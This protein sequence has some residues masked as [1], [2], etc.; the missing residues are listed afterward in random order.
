MEQDDHVTD[1]IRK[2]LDSSSYDEKWLQKLLF[3]RPDLLVTEKFDRPIIPICRELPLKSASAT[4]FLDLFCV[5][6]DGKP[7]LVECKLWRNPQARREVIG[8]ILEYA[9]LLQGLSFSDL[10]AI[11]GPKLSVSGPNPIF[12]AAKAFT[13]KLIE[14]DFV[15]RC[16]SYLAGGELD[17]IIAGDG[18][19]SDIAGIRDLLESRGGLAS[20]LS[21]LEVEIFESQQGDV[22]VQSTTQMKTQTVAMTVRSPHQMPVEDASAADESVIARSEGKSDWKIQCKQFWQQF[23]DELKLDHPAQDP[24]R[25]SVSNTVRLP[26]PKPASHITCFRVRKWKIVGVFVILDDTDEGR[27]YYLQLLE[28]KDRLEE[29]IGHVV[30]FS[31]KTDWSSNPFI[32]VETTQFD[33]E[34]STQEPAQLEYLHTHLNRF[35]NALRRRLP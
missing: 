30:K 17:L 27:A 14:K 13:P 6:D 3:D 12:Q 29:E 28:E 16:H 19:R 33:I 5:R 31:E 18:I 25:H 8:Q 26:F 7:V 24:P 2:P 10:E 23:I 9:S 20:R 35:V 22:L 32:S 34:D 15:D 11:V 1:F 4:V 21:L